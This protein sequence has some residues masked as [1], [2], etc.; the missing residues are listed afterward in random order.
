MNKT[1]QLAELMKP[2]LELQR[3]LLHE[4][5]IFEYLTATNDFDR[6]FVDATGNNRLIHMF[7]VV[8]DIFSLSVY[9]RFQEDDIRHKNHLEDHIK[10]LEAVKNQNH[11]EVL[12]VL[13]HH[14][15]Q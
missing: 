10:I 1:G 6:A 13:K 8:N 15:R 5:R 12:E 4:D 14:Y 2:R 7:T 11:A 3:K 9:E